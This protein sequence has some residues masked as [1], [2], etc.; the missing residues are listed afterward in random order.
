MPA[1]K[2]AE[3]ARLLAMD[4]AGEGRALTQQEDAASLMTSPGSALDAG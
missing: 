1:D 2:L 4:D 3:S